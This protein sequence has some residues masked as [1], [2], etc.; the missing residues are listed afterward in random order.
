MLGVWINV[1]LIVLHFDQNAWWVGLGDNIN[2][3][4]GFAI[5]VVLV[6][7]VFVWIL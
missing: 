7:I 4:Y 5:G 2:Q 1:L 3:D 6:L